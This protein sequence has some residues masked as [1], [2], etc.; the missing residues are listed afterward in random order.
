MKRIELLK[1]LALAVFIVLGA[2]ASHAS[3]HE[4]DIARADQPCST[5][6][7]FVTAQKP[8]QAFA[9]PRAHLG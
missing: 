5:T 9:L 2:V 6:V 3:S 1:A 8:A 4:A 7:M